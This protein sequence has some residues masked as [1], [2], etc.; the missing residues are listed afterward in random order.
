MKVFNVKRVEG[1]GA[2]PGEPLFFNREG[3]LV[4]GC[5]DGAVALLE[6]QLEGKKRMSSKDFINGF[7]EKI[8]F[9]Y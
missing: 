9:N 4:I 7:S 5:R 6:V 3:G 2:T 8:N 1:L